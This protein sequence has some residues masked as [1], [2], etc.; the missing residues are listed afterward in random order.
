MAKELMAGSE[1]PDSDQRTPGTSA[2]STTRRWSRSYVEILQEVR[3]A[4]IGTQLLLVFLLTLAFTGRF[5]QTTQFQRAVY[6]VSLVLGVAASC[7][8]IAPAPFHRL[9]FRRRMEAQLVKASSRFALWGVT[10]L[11]LALNAAL[12]LILD[13]VLGRAAAIWITA[14]T[15][16]WFLTWWYATPVWHRIGQR[17]RRQAATIAALAVASEK[18][19]LDADRPV[20]QKPPI[21]AARGLASAVPP[22]PVAPGPAQPA[23][24]APRLPLIPAPYP[25]LPPAHQLGYP[26]GALP[27]P[28]SRPSP[29]RPVPNPSAAAGPH[30]PGFRPP[31]AHHPGPTGPASPGRGSVVPG[32]GAGPHPTG[33]GRY[34]VPPRTYPAAAPSSNVANSNVPHSSVPS[35]VPTSGAP[36]NDAQTTSAP[37]SAGEAA[38]T[39]AFDVAAFDA[40]PFRGGAFQGAAARG[41]FFPAPMAGGEGNG[42]QHGRAIGFGTQY[43]R[44]EGNGMQHGRPDGNG[45]QHGR[46]DGN[47]MQHGLADGNGMQHGNLAAGTGAH[48]QL[49]DPGTGAHHLLSDAGAQDQVVIDG[50]PGYRYSSDGSGPQLGSGT[51]AHRL[52][53][54]TG[55]DPLVSDF[56]LAEE[57]QPTQVG[58]SVTPAP[59]ASTEDG[60][61]P[62]DDGGGPTKAFGR[63]S[64]AP[65]SGGATPPREDELPA[66][67]VDGEYPTEA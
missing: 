61:C 26:A 1:G 34:P 30:P 22:Q 38:A 7:L 64:V 8:L 16:A 44:A 17:K 50:G 49:S 2:D 41:P 52:L 18:L 65:P 19:R 32:P 59:S 28:V 66:P 55:S 63:A 24:G 20:R 42:M 10:L 40:T 21:P 15:L 29:R 33:P 45:M 25:A 39:M 58:I 37:M 9:V 23:A 56:E 54:D 57:D 12:L 43:G 11:M 6:V 13:I 46:A 67:H 4:Q 27:V 14:G 35:N 48:R 3:G 60:H 51:G 53:S 5:G 47:G 62:D 36:T 31:G